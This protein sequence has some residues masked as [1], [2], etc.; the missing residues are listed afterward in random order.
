VHQLPIIIAPFLFAIP[1]L[2][3]T[4]TLYPNEAPCLSHGGRGRPA[5]Q[6]GRVKGIWAKR[7]VWIPA[8]AGMTLSSPFIRLKYYEKLRSPFSEANPLP[9]KE[10]QAGWFLFDPGLGVC[11]TKWSGLGVGDLYR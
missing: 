2:R 6:A 3:K 4:V 7:G 10:L 11:N 8:S 5:V 1:R 9:T